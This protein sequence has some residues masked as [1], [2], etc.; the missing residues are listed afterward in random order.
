MADGETYY[1]VVRA[2]NAL[3]LD[4]TVRSDGITVKRDPLVPGQ[5]YDGLLVGFDLTYQK[6]T[7]TISAS[8]KGFGQ[9]MPVGEAVHHTG[10]SQL[11]LLYKTFRLI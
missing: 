8:W 6:A 9:G 10:I 11:D 4:I 1:S 3:G 2:T 7:D 5:V